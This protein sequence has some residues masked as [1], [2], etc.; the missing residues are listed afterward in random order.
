MSAYRE[1]TGRFG[2]GAAGEIFSRNATL[3]PLRFGGKG[4][5]GYFSKHT[6]GFG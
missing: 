4:F 5:F 1:M 3:R 6:V 2:T